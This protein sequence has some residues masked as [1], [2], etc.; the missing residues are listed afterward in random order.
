MELPSRFQIGEHVEFTLAGGHIGVWGEVVAV[1]FTKA[2]IFYDIID[3]TAADIHRD[4]DSCDVIPI[5]ESLSL[6]VETV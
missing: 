5:K 2:K 3:D 1:R 6:K 4:I